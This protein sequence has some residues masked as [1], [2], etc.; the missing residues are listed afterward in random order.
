MIRA[1]FTIIA[2]FL[3][4]S[5]TSISAAEAETITITVDSNNLRFSPSIIT[6]NEGDSVQFLWNGEI[7]AHNAV[8]Q[9]GIFDSGDTSRDVDYTFTFEIGTAGEYNFVCEPHE[10]AGMTGTIT[11]NSVE[12]SAPESEPKKESMPGFSLLILMAALISAT[13]V[14]KD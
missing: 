12:I 11:V 2:L 1:W 4:A 3:L 5:V 14:A 8:A 9:S 10:S 7:L 6:I 13:I